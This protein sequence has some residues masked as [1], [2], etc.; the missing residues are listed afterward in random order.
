MNAVTIFAPISKGHIDVEKRMVYG[1]AQLEESV[2]DLQ[3]DIVSWEATK[4]AFGLWA[5]NVREMHDRTKA[6]GKALFI[7]PLEDEK[8]MLVG[9][10][11]SKGAEDTWQKVLDGTLTGFSIGGFAT[12]TEKVF[13]PKLRRRVNKVLDYR[14]QELSLVDVPANPKCKVMAVQK[15]FVAPGISGDASGKA[16]KM[17]K[18]LDAILEMAKSLG[19][20]E[21][22]I[23]M[24]ASD[25][26]VVKGEGDAETIVLK[27][28]AGVVELQKG[29]LEAIG[30]IEPENNTAE[31]VA[32]VAKNFV[33]L[34]K[35]ADVDPL[36]IIA[37]LDETPSFVGGTTPVNKGLSKEEIVALAKSAVGTEV[38]ALA[39]AFDEL[40]TTITTAAPAARKGSEGSG[41]PVVKT[42]D[43][44]QTNEAETEQLRKNYKDAVEKRGQLIAKMDSGQALTSQEQTEA[45]QVGV[46]IDRLETKAAQ[47]GVSLS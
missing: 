5:G 21:N 9:V 39:K 10:R 13:D 45:T 30:E 2:P 27:A 23:L 11:V 42:A 14:L 46:T 41:T 18:A 43:G 6:V 16:E 31:I 38:Q 3:G 1:V 22:V 20:D 37:T 33:A 40:K 32:E 29:D 35:A 24:K 7:K 12:R 15:N 17:S 8:K 28:D 44:G 25:I 4:K 26:E 36:E 19:D 47:L 34:A